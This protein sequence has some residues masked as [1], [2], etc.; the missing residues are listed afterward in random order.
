MLQK[1]FI[2]LLFACVMLSLACSAPK[3]LK[4][5]NGQINELTQQNSQLKSTV[6]SLKN[7]VVVC[8]ES[9][10]TM[11]DEL[12]RSKA[13]NRKTQ[14]KLEAS[15]AILKEQYNIMQ[16][17]QGKIDA[18]LEDFKDK[19]V[20][21]SFKKGLVYVSLEDKLL[22]KT[23]SSKLDANGKKALE[24]L[25]LVLNEYPNLKVIVLGNT[26]DVLF[27]KGTDNWTL[28]TERANGVIRLLINEGKM[29]PT[30]LTAAGKGRF[31]PIADNTTPDGKAKNRR[32]DI[33][34]NPNLDTI[35]DSIER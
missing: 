15:Q 14:E 27:K 19:G 33:I 28:S 34:L 12:N 6:S 4:A 3:K 29:E 31:N 32:T 21:V 1:L 17:V 24:D 23:G 11:S 10:K 5:A 16:Q 20:E 30:R 22:Y 2:T 13:E 26:D 7:E 8:A 25:A 35:W 9:N 18:A